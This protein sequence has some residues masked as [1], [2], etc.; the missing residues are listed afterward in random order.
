MAKAWQCCGKGN[1][2]GLWKDGGTITYS[3]VGA[4]QLDQ[5]SFAMVSE[6][7]FLAL[8]ATAYDPFMQLTSPPDSLTITSVSTAC[9]EGVMFIRAAAAT[10]AG[11][12]KMSGG[13][14]T[15]A[16][17]Y[18]TDFLSFGMTK[19][20]EEQPSSSESES[21]SSTFREDDDSRRKLFF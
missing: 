21:A 4:I 15:E 11:L 1:G 8:A 12:D 16:P 5:T 10:T 19:F 18:L 6:T 17:T 7:D 14:V 20:S 3:A 9:S 13:F 2:A